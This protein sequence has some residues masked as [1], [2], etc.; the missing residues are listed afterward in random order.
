M[1]A[2][3]IAHIAQRHAAR[4]VTNG[5]FANWGLGL[6]SALLGNSGGADDGANGRRRHDQ[7]HLPE[8]QS[9]R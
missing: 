1:L 2:H 3:E 5:A 4:Q 8:V 7:R 9:R 6:L